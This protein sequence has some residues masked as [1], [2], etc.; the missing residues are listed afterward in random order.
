[1]QAESRPRP[2][3][4][5][6]WRLGES[7]AA[8]SRRQFF[9]SFAAHIASGYKGLMNTQWNALKT[10]LAAK[11]EPGSFKVWIMPLE[12]KVSDGTLH[13]LAPNA[14][15]ARW[16]RNKLTNCIEACLRELSY[17]LRLEIGVGAQKKESCA[18]GQAETKKT[19]AKKD[20]S[21]RRIQPDLP[22]ASRARIQK[23]AWRHSFQDFVEGESNRLALAAAKEVCREKSDIQTLYVNSS[24]GLGKTHLVQAVGQD[25]T[26]QGQERV[27]YLTA[28]EF[29][30][31][32]VA[33]LKNND[34]ESFKDELRNLDVLLLED[35]HFLQNKPK[36]QET[37]LSIV[38][39]LQDHGGRVIFTSSF[40]PKEIEKVDRAFYANFCANGV[41]TRI[42]NPDASMRSEIISRKAHSAHM[43]ISDAV[44][45]L[46]A[47][48][49]DGN[50]RQIES[51]LQSIFFKANLLHSEITTELALGVLKEYVNLVRSPDLTLLTNLVCQNYGLDAETLSSRSRCQRNV[52]GRNTIFYLA[53][54]HTDLTL[55]E[56]GQPFS[57]RHSTVLQGIT[58][59]EKELSMNSP[60][61]RQIA[62]VVSLVE[63]HVGAKRVEHA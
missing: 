21:V 50:V 36:I 27:N 33:S 38:R 37:A 17:D 54:K 4:E 9:V 42:E 63:E 2:C 14:Y 23:R 49:L 41:I 47:T 10:M 1:M 48:S 30:S 16:V 34:V 61:G 13:L 58:A 26:M 52:L 45:T 53:R 43:R 56:I 35:I 62:R 25:I 12:A 59:V 57:R 31:R 8:F 32:Y 44:C 5:G 39:G 18:Q 20:E 6:N 46:I 60:L 22:G 51:C 3:A 55:K 15:M 29:S 11:L 28:D 19:E 24:S 7:G 40:T